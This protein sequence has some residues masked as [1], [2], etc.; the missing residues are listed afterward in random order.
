MMTAILSDRRVSTEGFDRH[1][2]FVDGRRVVYYSAGQGDT[3]L[4]LHGAGT[5]HGFSFTR[6][7]S[8]DFQVI[9]PYHPGWG[10]SDDN[11]KIESISDYVDHYATFL[12]LLGLGRVHLV[13]SSMGGRIAAEFAYMH[14]ERVDRLVLACP[15]GLDVPQHPMT[16]LSAIAPADVPSYLVADPSVLLPFLPDEPD[17]EF[18]AMREREGKTLARVLSTTGFIHPSMDRIAGQIAAPTLLLW[19]NSDR[20]IPIEQ[21]NAWMQLL[22][23]GNVTKLDAI[24]HLVFDESPAARSHA[25]T[26]LATGSPGE[27]D[28]EQA[29]RKSF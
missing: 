29:L 22:L 28:S 7:W 14:H 5:F 3:L 23:H 9:V 18:S 26:F 11:P 16:D 15:A 6:Q 24:G 19:G 25:Q 8:E 20:L 27:A 21:S 12:D 17:S 1:E 13:G 2:V 10:E 4:Y